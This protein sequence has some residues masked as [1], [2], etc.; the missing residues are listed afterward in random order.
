MLGKPLRDCPAFSSKSARALAVPGSPRTAPEALLCCRRMFPGGEGFRWEAAARRLL[1]GGVVLFGVWTLWCWTLQSLGA[2]FNTLVALAW[3]PL[4][5][6][7]GA[8]RWLP[9]SAALG[10]PGEAGAE[11]LRP[12]ALVCAVAVAGLVVALAI[13]TGSRA[14]PV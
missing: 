10:R 2:S 12:R 8:L 7:A 1:A 4:V 9:A 11:P 14:Y 5:A 6:A 3:V 13:A